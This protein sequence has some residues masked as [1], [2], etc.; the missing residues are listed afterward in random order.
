MYTENKLKNIIYITLLVLIQFHSMS[1]QLS[2]TVEKG[3]FI[4]E[5][6]FKLLFFVN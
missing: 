6:F 4:V 5:K 3:F 1:N 2:K